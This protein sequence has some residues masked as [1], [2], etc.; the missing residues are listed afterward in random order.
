MIDG[1]APHAS[2]P[3]RIATGVGHHAGPPVDA[4]RD[5]LAGRS[6]DAVVAGD[7]AVRCLKMRAVVFVRV[8][9][10]RRGLP[11][12]RVLWRLRARHLNDGDREHER[13]KP[14]HG[15]EHAMLPYQPWVRLPSAQSHSTIEHHLLLTVRR[16]VDG[17]PEA[18]AAQDV[19]PLAHRESGAPARRPSSSSRRSTRSRSAM[20]SIIGDHCRPSPPWSLNVLP[21]AVRR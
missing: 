11:G 4:D 8:D 7:A 18:D 12:P 9:V 19:H 14:A 5:V 6:G 20:I 16:V 1:F 10:G 21:I 3:V 15:P 2:H 17:D 13:K